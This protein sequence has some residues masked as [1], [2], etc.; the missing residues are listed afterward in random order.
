M[1]LES[2]LYKIQD[3]MEDFIYFVFIFLNEL[4]CHVSGEAHETKREK[5]S[6]G[7]QSSNEKRK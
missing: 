4:I 6:H 2:N 5:D 7:R 3:D 1:I